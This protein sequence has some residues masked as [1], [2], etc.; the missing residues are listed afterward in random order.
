MK[1]EYARTKLVS[2]SEALSMPEQ[3]ALRLGV[4][5]DTHS[6]LHPR[7][8]EHLR[9]LAPHALLHAGDIGDLRVLDE[10]REVAPVHAVRG[11]I[12]TRAPSLP[13]LLTIEI[14]AGERV[15]LRMLL[16]HIAVY[17]PKL[18]SEVARRALAD[19][20]S[21]VV[22]G[23]SHVPFIGRD[24]GLTLFNPGSAGPRRFSLPILFGSLELEGE[25]VRLRHIECETGETWLPPALPAL[26]KPAR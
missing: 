15:M 22:C 14:K 25:R 26:S 1:S 10:L 4:I 18:R 2:R 17:G 5:A 24:R 20:A 13:D 19:K 7:T 8:L 9:A 6:A 16:L 23:H 21:L 11:N 3:G 12:D